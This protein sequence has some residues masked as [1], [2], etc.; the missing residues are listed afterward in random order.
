MLGPVEVAVNGL[1]NITARTVVLLT[2]ALVLLIHTTLLAAA[3]AAAWYWEVS[4]SEVK[5]WVGSLVPPAL[6]A[7]AGG[8]LAF[9]GISAGALLVL[10]AKGWQWLLR[11]MA[12][13]Y[14]LNFE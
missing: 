4:P 1:V 5:T 8:T 3:V 14:V 11:K 7:I 6:A 10:Y 12:N 9:V 13:A 2:W